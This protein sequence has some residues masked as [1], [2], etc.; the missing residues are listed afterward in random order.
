MHSFLTRR[1]ICVWS[2]IVVFA[3]AAGVGAFAQEQGQAS[4]PEQENAATLRPEEQP[5]GILPI[6]EFNG[7]FW[8]RDRL[9]GDWNGGRTW[10][11]ERGLQFELDFT[12]HVQSNVS[13]GR[14]TGTKYGGSL[15]YLLRFDLDR[16]GALPGALVSFRGESRYGESVNGLTGSLL[17]ANT[18]LFF[19]ITSELDE[20]V[21]FAITELTYTQYLSPKFAIFV[22]KLNTL[23]GGGD[24]NE[25]ASGRGKT[26]FSNSNFVFHP[27]TA[28]AVPYTT[29]GG[30]AIFAPSQ[31]VQLSASVFNSADAS[32]TSGF[33]D[34]GDGWTLSGEAQ[35]KYAL[36]KLP[37]GMNVG[38]LYA[39]DGDFR[40]LSGRF[41]FVPGEGLAA[42]TKNNT[43]SVYWTGWQYVWVDES[44]ET[45]IDP[46]NGVPDRRGVGLFAR[47]G[48]GDDDTLPIEWSVSGGVGGRGLVPGRPDDHF[49]VGYYYS[50]VD[51]DRLTSFQRVDRYVQGV[52]AY[53]NLALGGAAHFTLSI[54]A[55]DS[56]L[57]DAETA[58]VLGARL[59]VRF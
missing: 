17:A 48:F 9:T 16:M 11:A 51:E 31:H 29:L 56:A 40:D 36:G 4:T 8:E 39:D 37:G 50:R 53:Y 59:G 3:Q 13:G 2:C 35:F 43:W 23:A 41:V 27:V 46:T 52:E 6:P 32:E 38:G 57:G 5:R 14:D 58:L 30:G 26:Q 10:L 19:P 12:Q 15:E 34:F 24:P 25:F 55:L 1:R 18:D 49:G 20:E 54:Q 47:V 21:A 28:L 33:D 22:G 44:D 45:P 7:G 42:P